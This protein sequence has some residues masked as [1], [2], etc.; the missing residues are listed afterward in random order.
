MS[1]DR[2][3][4]LVTGEYFAKK[5]P[6]VVQRSSNDSH[7]GIR[8]F[9]RLSFGDSLEKSPFTSWDFAHRI[10]TF[11]PENTIYF[12]DTN[13]FSKEI[14]RLV[15]EALLTRRIAITPLIHQE[16]QPWLQTPFHN[17]DMRNAVLEAEQHGPDGWLDRLLEGCPRAEQS[18]R[19]I[20]PQLTNAFFDH[21]YQH[22]HNLLTIRRLIG[23]EIADEMQRQTG[24]PPSQEA[25]MKEMMIRLGDRGFRVAKEAV[26][27]GVS[28]T[29][30]ADE[31]MLLM[32]ALTAVCSGQPTVILTRDTAI[33]EQFRKLWHLM[34]SDYVAHWC[35]EWASSGA[36][37]AEFKRFE[38][39]EVEY[40]FCLGNE[41]SVLSAY[42][43]GFEQA[44]LPQDFQPAIC[45]CLV[46]GG[47]P[48]KMVVSP[49]V[50]CAEREMAGFLQTKARSGGKNSERFGDL[51]CVVS[52]DN[53]LVDGKVIMMLFLLQPR[54]VECCSMR[55]SFMDRHAALMTSEL[56]IRF[57]KSD[58][59][60][61]TTYDA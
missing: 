35:G 43:D 56:V 47:E 60:L 15:W 5:R 40:D 6:L 38:G 33:Q 34:N 20:F 48:T 2:K 27:E 53:K 17:H 7:L 19:I 21:G 37:I 3:K 16:I 23:L 11:F 8:P 26:E 25:L 54:I 22:Y 32:A 30:L 50:Y 24:Q 45:A 46:V 31:Q 58:I 52:C 9:R 12:P 57:Q 4:Y 39:D 10:C 14:G 41:I 1:R 49:D 51:D 61:P 55:V 18:Q 59:I 13:F 28:P 42:K 44:V 36:N 29:F